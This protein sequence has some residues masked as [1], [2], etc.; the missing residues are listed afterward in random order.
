MFRNAFCE[1]IFKNKYKHE[2]A[3]T[4]EELSRTLVE[5][6]CSG[7]LTE[8]EIEELIQYHSEMKWI[9]GGRYLYYAGRLNKFFNNCY[10]LKA[11][12][13]NREDW[14]NL[15]WK[16][17]SCLMTGGGIGIDYSVYRPKGSLIKRTGGF[18]SGTV[19]KMEMI[20]EI[21]RR[22]MQ[23]GSRRSAIYAS[24]NWRH[25]DVESF[26]HAKDWYNIP[27]NGAYD[28]EGNV[29][30]I[31][32]MKELD[33]NY[34]AP[35]DMTNVSLNY[36]N[37][38]LEYIYEIPFDELLKIYKEKGKKG[39]FELPIIKLPVTFVEN[40]RQALKTGEPGF[41]FNFF[42]KVL[43]TLRNACTEVTSEDD[44]DVCNLASLNMSRIKTIEEFSRIAY[45]VSKFLVC[46]TLKADLPYQKVKEIR[47]KNRRLGLGLMGIHEWLLS[48]GYKYEVV[49]ELHNWLKEYKDNSEL[50]ANKLCDELK[51]SRPAA[52]RAIAPTGKILC[53]AA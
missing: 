1:A 2:K 6:V 15:S 38:F 22:V 31:G 8:E 35:L 39:I 10:L 17:E 21:G 4:W 40:C 53:L 29:M 37:E 3:N 20:N 24:L 43:E 30:T 32:K 27:I 12:V 49:P 52:Y 14:A 47:E 50:G 48:R 41:S 16:S 7:I 36:D 34:P 33:F 44:S 51:I 13:D 28:E 26:L 23:G 19:S 46:G 11:C 42:E 25:G 18:A 45:L 5:D 9:A